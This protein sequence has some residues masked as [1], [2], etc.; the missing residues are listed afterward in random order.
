MNTTTELN[1]YFE[2]VYLV[3]F[4]EDLNVYVYKDLYVYFLNVL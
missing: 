4:K 3:N 2:F 1:K